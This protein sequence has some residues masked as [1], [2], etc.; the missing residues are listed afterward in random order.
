MNETIHYAADDQGIVTLTIDQPGQS[1]NTMNPVFR[2]A[3]EAAIDRLEA[4]RDQIRGVILTSGKKTFFAGGDLNS[5]RA[6]RPADSEMLFERSNALKSL[7]RR[8]E[9][10]GPPVVA[11][12][13]GTALGGGFELALACHARFALDDARI[14]LG[15]PEVSLGLLPGAGG[16]VRTVRML[17]VEAAAALIVDAVTFN[18]R[19]AVELGL[20]DGLAKDP[21]ELLALARQWI[22]AN[23][24]PR[25]PWDV[26]GFRV[27]GASGASAAP[28]P[29]LRNAPLALIR[30][31][32]SLYPAPE[33]RAGG[34][35]GMR[36]CRLR[37][38]VQ[39]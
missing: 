10:F 15:L 8:L 14:A 30:K 16:V 24:A 35:G 21:G 1:T 20:V 25:Q 12:L 7:M 4:E 13:N 3:F 23:P 9:T 33:V 31:Y 32:R 2:A 36:Q 6:A 34:V 19:R 17:G 37:E 5:L 26:K 29:Y 18:P 38:R 28:L 22:A 39:D 27:P 11:A